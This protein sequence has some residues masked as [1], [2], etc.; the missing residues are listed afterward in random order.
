MSM[1]NENP[2]NYVNMS[3]AVSDALR[4]RGATEDAVDAGYGAGLQTHS[5]LGQPV[6]AAGAPSGGKKRGRP[7][8]PKGAKN[9]K[10]KEEEEPEVEGGKRKRGRPKGGKKGG[11]RKANPWLDHVKKFKADHPDMKYSDV[12]KKAKDT[13]ER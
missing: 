11:A 6:I 1:I 13:Y 4:R 5:I 12:L 7:G 9:K 10:K 8:R 2:C 3:A